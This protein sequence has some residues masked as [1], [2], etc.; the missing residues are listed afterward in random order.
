MTGTLSLWGMLQTAPTILDDFECPD[1][2]DR[3]LLLSNIVIECAE[4]E[5]LYSDAEF[6]QAAVG[7][8]SA[9]Q[10]STWQK[11]YNAEIAQ[12]NPIENY[13]RAESWTDTVSGVTNTTTTNGST[14][15]G[16]NSGNIV[17]KVTGY[18]SDTLTPRGG[19]DSTGTSTNTVTETGSGDTSSSSNATHV[20][21]VSGN[22]GVRSN[23]ELLE[24]EIALAPKLN[25]YNYI[26]NAFKQRFCLLVYT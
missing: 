24:Q 16:T 2:L 13:N 26:T 4:L 22:I 6:M 3:E 10:L 20:G 9:S 14:S 12:Y 17:E 23:Q 7:I 19:S 18:N 21:N 5:V 25:T 1:G 11:L 8:W 15:T